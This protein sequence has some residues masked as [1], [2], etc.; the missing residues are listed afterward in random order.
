[1]Q[2][3]RFYSFGEFRVDVEEEILW[4]GDEKLHINRRTF[5]VLRLLIE[6]AGKIVSKQEFA[7]KVWSDTFVE[8]N[9]L[10][11]TM[12]TLRKI[13]GDSAKEEKFIENVPRKGYCFIGKVENPTE[14]IV[15][16]P[17]KTNLFDV[18]R[19]RKILV[20]LFA[21]TMLF[22]LFGFVFDKVQTKTK[23]ID[24]RQKPSL[25]V[26]PFTNLQ[27]NE[28][29]DYLGYAFADT[30]NAKLTSMRSFK[31]FPSS[32]MAKYC[33]SQISYEQISLELNAQYIVTGTYLK[34]SEQVIIT[35]Q[36]IDAAKNETLFQDNFHLKDNQLSQLQEIIARR[37][38]TELRLRSDEIKNY[39]TLS[40]IN[41]QAYNFYLKGIE[42]YSKV[43]LDTSI[44]NLEKAVALAPDFAD[45]W[46]RLG[47][48]YMVS[49]STRFGG[50]EFYQKAERA[51][52]KS[53]ELDASNSAP[54]IHLA[55]M[56][57]ETNR[58]EK[59]VEILLKTLEQEP[60]NGLVWWE[61][62]YAYRYAGML[63]KSIAAGEKA[64]EVDPGFFLRTAVPSYYLYAGQYEKFKNALPQR[65]DS[66]YIKFY[67]GFAEYHL[68]N[69]E[70]AQQLF[71]EAY[72]LDS[73]SMQPQ[74]GKALSYFISGNN[75][76]AF[77][78]LDKTEKEIIEKNVSDGEK[79]YKVAQAFAVLGEKEKALRLFDKSVE[80][81]FYCY[82]YFLNDP[83]LNNLR[84]EPKFVEIMEKARLQ[85]ET[86]KT[87]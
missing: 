72:Q 67:Q 3:S 31:V 27:P 26:M 35:A 62:S 30:I 8:D 44:E 33:N 86:F 60:E 36:F 59:A 83:L 69:K 42:Q 4:R 43:Q 14:K 75:A 52:Q 84:S 1:M 46:N 82:Q 63:E 7:D 5:Q 66:A 57:I 37:L 55:D 25:A 11:V 76:E 2:K 17:P 19:A 85:Y 38:I 45:A 32:V 9:S 40:D 68:N 12:N 87:N 58:K 6:N 13:L 81:G 48:S 71:D 51:F 56:M 74:T 18:I 10:T 79:I 78:L 21:G 16:L 73:G 61:L 23:S 54:Q 47:T 70:S 20:G 64:S 39:S 24:F 29:T 15:S 49:A 41:P 34:E 28:N 53:I 22:L 65:S 77:R 50:S 80:T